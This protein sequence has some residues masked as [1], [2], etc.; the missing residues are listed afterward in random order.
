MFILRA[1]DDSH[2]AGADLLKDQE[3]AKSLSDRNRA[4]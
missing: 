1:I 3:V 2:A 4:H